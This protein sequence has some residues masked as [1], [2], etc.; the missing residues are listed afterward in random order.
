M[1]QSQVRCYSGYHS[2]AHLEPGSW[3]LFLENSVQA[4]LIRMK[5]RM[6]SGYHLCAASCES[7]PPAHKSPSLLLRLAL[8]PVRQEASHEQREAAPLA[9]RPIAA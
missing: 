7:I 4:I 8:G 1:A 3:H 5:G 2:L 6:S 9:E